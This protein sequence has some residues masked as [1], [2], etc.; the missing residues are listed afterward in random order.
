MGGYY[1]V[2]KPG[3]SSPDCV[4]VMSLFS[5]GKGQPSIWWWKNMNSVK[6]KKK[7]RKKG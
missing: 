4:Q 3:V 1:S 2:G 6:K 7:E 5:T